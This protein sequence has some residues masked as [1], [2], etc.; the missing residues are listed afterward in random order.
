M[1][2][3][4]KTWICGAGYCLAA[5]MAIFAAL[6]LGDPYQSKAFLWTFFSVAAVISIVCTLVLTKKA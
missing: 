5:V 4:M 2:I 3:G 1:L 6:R